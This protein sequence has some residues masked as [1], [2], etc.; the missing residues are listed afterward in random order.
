MARNFKVTI[1]GILLT[2][3]LGSPACEVTEELGDGYYYSERC[4][5]S[6]SNRVQDI[7]AKVLDYKYDCQFIIAK[8]KCDAYIPERLKPIEIQPPYDKNG[9]AYWLIDMSIPFTFGPMDYSSF[10]ELCHEK[11]VTLSFEAQGFITRFFQYLNS[12]LG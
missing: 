1:I 9:I 12:Q 10:V 3:L 5:F 11:G 4:I 7:P 8:Q 6:K 2:V